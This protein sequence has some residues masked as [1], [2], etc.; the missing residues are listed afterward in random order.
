VVIAADGALTFFK[1]N[2]INPH[3]ILGDWDSAD[4]SFRKS[5]PDSEIISIPEQNKQFTD[6]EYALKWCR[7]NSIKD[8]IIYGGI[9]TVFET[10]HLMGNILMMFAYLK[11]FDSIVMRDYSQEIIPV[12]DG[13]VSGEGKAGD[14]IS[15]IPLGASIRYEARGLKYN[16][17]GKKYNFGSS[18]PLRNQIKN[19]RFQIEIKGKAVVVRHFR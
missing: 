13:I 14:N 1:N 4:Y 11:D 7:E 8:V 15:V 9:D 17:L 19:K 6:G 16:P 5:F 18:T 10:D 12:V 3:L 2:K